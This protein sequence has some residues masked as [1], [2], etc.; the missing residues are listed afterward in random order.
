[1]Q[2]HPAGEAVLLKNQLLGRV[3]HGELCILG[4]CGFS[5]ECRLLLLVLSLLAFG[6]VSA[7]TG[8]IRCAALVC[9]MK[10]R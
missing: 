9:D 8:E 2:L 10:A 3:R 1:M 5:P 6:L 7:H 4:Q